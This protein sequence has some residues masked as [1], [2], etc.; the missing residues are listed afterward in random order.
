MDETPEQVTEVVDAVPEETTE[1]VDETPD[2]VETPS[3]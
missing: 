1:T 3:E 2:A